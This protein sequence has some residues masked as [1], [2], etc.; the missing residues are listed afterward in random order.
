MTE[1]ET[2]AIALLKSIDESL[3][4]L[5]EASEREARKE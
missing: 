5:R 2:A 4:V 1:F 3:K